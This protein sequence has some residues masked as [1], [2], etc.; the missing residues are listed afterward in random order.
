ML[1]LRYALTCCFVDRLKSATK[2]LTRAHHCHSLIPFIHDMHFTLAR[3]R[4][5]FVLTRENF[6]SNYHF[7][8]IK[9]FIHHDNLYGVIK[10]ATRKCH[11][12]EN[13]KK[14]RRV[15]RN[16][17]SGYYIARPSAKNKIKKIQNGNRP[18]LGRIEERTNELQKMKRKK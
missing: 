4:S 10:K 1:L 3:F 17:Q 7:S 15:N 5:Y 12:K 11:G 13:Q 8:T 6:P 14:K 16:A 2:R 9:S 18:T